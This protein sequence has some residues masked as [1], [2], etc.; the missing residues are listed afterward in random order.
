MLMQSEY[1]VREGSPLTTIELLPA[2]PD[3]WKDG[4]VSGIRARGGI[5]VDMTWKD[6]QVT[7]LTLTAQ[8]PCTVTLLANGQQQ[9]LKL[10]KGALACW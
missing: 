5:T 8:H 7:S 3:N 4:S 10:K 2:L 1:T 6:K 9:T